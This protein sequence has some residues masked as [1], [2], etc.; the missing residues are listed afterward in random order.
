M[1]CCTSP[2]IRRC[3]SSSALSVA[4]A[5]RTKRRTTKKATRMEKM[6]GQR[7]DLSPGL[8]GS[9][10]RKHNINTHSTSN[11]AGCWWFVGPEGGVAGCWVEEQVGARRAIRRRKMTNQKKYLHHPQHPVDTEHTPVKQTVVLVTTACEMEPGRLHMSRN[12]TARGGR[13]TRR[14]PTN[15]TRNPTNER[16]NERTHNTQSAL[17][18]ARGK[19]YPMILSGRPN[20]FSDCTTIQM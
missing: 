16:T 18:F 7:Q 5:A 15:P 9:A 2:A 10:I 11:T 4:H 20:T 1:F 14:R 8:F 3:R 17:T 13:S 6:A 19:R 12:Q